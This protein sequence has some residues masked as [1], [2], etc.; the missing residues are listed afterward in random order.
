M[1]GMIGGVH[2]SVLHDDVTGNGVRRCSTG[3]FLSEPRP[4]VRARWTP[5]IFP[6]TCFLILKKNSL[7]K[8]IYLV[9]LLD[10]DV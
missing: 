1:D 7:N 4:H 6:E 8:S 5:I 10:E 2:C 3:P 9:T